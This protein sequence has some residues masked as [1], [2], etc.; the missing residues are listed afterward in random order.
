[1]RHPMRHLALL[2]CAGLLLTACSMPRLGL[3]RVHKVT[4]QQGN[5]INQDM[6]DK[7]KPGM[8]RSQVAYIM[9]EPVFRNP[10]NDDRWDYIYTIEVPGYY[11]DQKRVSLYFEN[12]VLAYFT[13]DFAPSDAEKPGES[14]QTPD[15]EP[16]LPEDATSDS[17]TGGI[18]NPATA[19]V[20]GP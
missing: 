7:L 6:I 8:S 15:G 19:G 10:F 17:E 9:G 3:P 4:V 14:P 20:N 11:D 1:M 18:A 13:G 2:V 5:V 16:A 12:N